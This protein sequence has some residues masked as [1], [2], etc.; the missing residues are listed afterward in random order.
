MV[1][2]HALNG[3]CCSLDLVVKIVKTCILYMI[4]TLQSLYTNRKGN[5]M[6][7]ELIKF[8]ILD[9]TSYLDG[10]GAS[11]IQT[12]GEFAIM[13]LLDVDGETR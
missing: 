10:I 6:F 7:R 5:E 3:R 2:P 1:L 8:H 12:N 4:H 11:L 9:P 13:C